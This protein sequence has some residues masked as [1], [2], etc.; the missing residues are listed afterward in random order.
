MEKNT[1]FEG[2]CNYLLNLLACFPT[3]LQHLYVLPAC[4]MIMRKGLQDFGFTSKGCL[5]FMFHRFP[6]TSNYDVGEDM[7]S[8]RRECRERN[9]P[10]ER[11]IR[12]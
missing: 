6:M 11:N 8:V 1:E 3:S 12:E 9:G 10:N 4:A 5:P 2:G 7:A